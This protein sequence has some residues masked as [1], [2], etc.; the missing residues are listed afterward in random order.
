MSTNPT[1]YELIDEQL[2]ELKDKA[3]KLQLV[4]DFPDRIGFGPI[5]GKDLR[6]T[7]ALL[8]RMN[9]TSAST[10]QYIESFRPKAEQSVDGHEL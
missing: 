1:I 2:A 7:Y 8:K 5:A 10:L 4:A 3:F 6:E 9:A